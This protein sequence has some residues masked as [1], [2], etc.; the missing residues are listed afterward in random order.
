MAGT[1]KSKVTVAVF[2]AVTC[3]GLYA[4]AVEPLMSERE[5]V[6]REPVSSG[7]KK[8]GMWKEIKQREQ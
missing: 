4:V 5:D 6:V 2:L 8:G 1:L 7:F 3:A